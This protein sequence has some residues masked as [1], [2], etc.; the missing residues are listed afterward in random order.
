[1][2]ALKYVLYAYN[3]IR[4]GV[5]VGCGVGFFVVGA[6][7]GLVGVGVGFFVGAAV[8]VSVISM[9]V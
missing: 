3:Y 1:M 8:C 6:L 7:V 2:N 9:K 5:A 4:V